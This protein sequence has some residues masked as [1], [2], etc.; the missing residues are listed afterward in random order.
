MW[1]GILGAAL[2]SSTLVLASPAQTTAARVTIITG[3]VRTS[4]GS[5][6]YGARVNVLS[7]QSAVLR[8]TSTNAVGKYTIVSNDSSRTFKVHAVMNGVKSADTVV[9]RSPEDDRI[10]LDIRLPRSLEVPDSAAE[11]PP[12]ERPSGSFKVVG[13]V[14]D[15]GTKPIA[16]ATVT[17]TGAS[18]TR[19]GPPLEAPRQGATDANGRFVVE[20]EG[21][22]PDYTVTIRAVGF[23]PSVLPPLFSGRRVHGDVT[24]EATLGTAAIIVSSPFPGTTVPRAT[25]GSADA[26]DFWVG[27][28]DIIV[29]GT[30]ENVVT[31]EV[32]Q[33]PGLHGADSTADAF[34]RPADYGTHVVDGFGIRVPGG[35]GTQLLIRVPRNLKTLKLTVSHYGDVRV[36]H[37][38]GE[39][40]VMSE[41]GAVTLL[42]ISGPAVIEAR[43]GAISAVVSKFPASKFSGFS[44]LGRNGGIDITIPGTAKFSV[45]VSATAGQV[46][47]D[48]E[49]SGNGTQV[50]SAITYYVRRD[51]PPAQS[52]PLHSR[53]VVN[54]GG[55]VV[56][57]VAMNGN[58]VIHKSPP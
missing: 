5:P 35:P 57:V 21:T 1:K 46:T 51:G 43:N 33:R 7:E 31:Y 41:R 11:R 4:S 42:D 49:K 12:A 15:R 45:E 30:D 3:T 13:T 27:G 9:T 55:T 23:A 18:A 26:A 19:G 50:D 38:D 40:T 20:L 14:R 54:G 8:Y 29:E 36:N 39:L 32:V 10:T 2:A 37:Y 25:M 16:G 28:G 44:L 53:V 34:M 47:S 52:G 22:A 17:V 24:L 58:V 56:N 48:F 6:V